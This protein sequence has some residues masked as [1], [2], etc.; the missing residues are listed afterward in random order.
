MYGITARLHFSGIKWCLRKMGVNLVPFPCLHFFL[1][2]PATLFAPA[3]GDKVK[4]TVAELQ[5]KCGVQ[6]TF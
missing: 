2:A 5:T 1:I 4:L 6:E 3:Q